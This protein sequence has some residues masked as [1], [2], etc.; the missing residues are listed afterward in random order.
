MKD[1]LPYI[2]H[3]NTMNKLCGIFCK[4]LPPSTDRNGR[5]LLLSYV[6]SYPAYIFHPQVGGRV[7]SIQNS[8]M[9]GNLDKNVYLNAKE[10]RSTTT[11]LSMMLMN[12]N[13]YKQAS[14]ACVY[15]L[16]LA[17]FQ[18]VYFVR[19]CCITFLIYILCSIPAPILVLFNPH[20]FLLSIYSQTPLYIAFV[21]FFASSQIAFAQYFLLT[22]VQR[23]IELHYCTFSGETFRKTT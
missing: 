3:K 6:V 5:I 21:G 9:V 20:L 13:T 15:Y 11:R 10:K 7:A 12:I 2:Y 16:C 8:D 22:L 17:Y 23:I 19:Y 14:T 18:D 1:I 4:N